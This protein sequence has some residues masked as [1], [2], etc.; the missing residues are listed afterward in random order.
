MQRLSM[1]VMQCFLPGCS[2][3]RDASTFS[4]ITKLE[5]KFHLMLY[6]HQFLTKYVDAIA[7]K[8]CVCLE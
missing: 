6:L 8:L 4:G 5:F 2:M 3:L 7:L 1:L